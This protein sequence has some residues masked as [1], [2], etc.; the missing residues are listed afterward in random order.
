MIDHNAA[1]FHGLIPPLVTPRTADG[2]IDVPGLEQL[3]KHLLAGGVHG[4]FVL[5]SSGEVPYLTNDERRQVVATVASANAGQV[6]LIVGA[7]EQTTNR[8]VEESRKAVSWGAD[9]VVATS[10]YYALS[11]RAELLTHFRSIHAA[12]DVPVFAY[13]VPVRTHVKLDAELVAE[14]GREGTIVGVKDSSGDDVSFRRLCLATKDLDGFAVFTGH[15]VV[16]DGAMLSGANGIVPGLAN[17]D[18]AGYR[19]LYDAAVAGDW[20]AARTEQDRLAL[21]FEIVTAADGARVSP[22]AA[23]LGAFKTALVQMGVF[24]SNVMTHPMAALNDAEA[25]T[26]R[27]YL[28]RAGLL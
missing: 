14:L 1:P 13:D 2:E 15:E 19:R 18:P 6:P 5:G 12:V 22:G 16:V 8:V 9:A 10:P 27:G 4:L 21:L 17:V 3:T 23:G 7:N 25:G 20:A 28:E 11:N 24:S 26:V